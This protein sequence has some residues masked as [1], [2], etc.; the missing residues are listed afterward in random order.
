MSRTAPAGEMGDAIPTTGHAPRPQPDGF[1]RIGGG[2]VF[3]LDVLKVT[4]PEGDA[5][6]GAAGANAKKQVSLDLDDLW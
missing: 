2:V 1:V 3:H 6:D 4:L 5:S